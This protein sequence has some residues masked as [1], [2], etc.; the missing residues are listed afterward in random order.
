MVTYSHQR[1]VLCLRLAALQVLHHIR[2]RPNEPIH[3]K[4]VAEILGKGV[5]RPLLSALPRGA[6]C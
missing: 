3:N 2:T 4:Y 6:A 1:S 5:R